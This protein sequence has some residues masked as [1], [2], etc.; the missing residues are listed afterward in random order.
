MNDLNDSMARPSPRPWYALQVHAKRESLVATQLEGQ[1]F[2]CFLPLY[3][4]VRRWSDRLKE[5]E[6]PLF[7]GY[8]FSRFDLQYR[9]PL[10]K[11]PGVQRIVGVGRTPMPV[12]ESEL[13]AIRQA[14]ASGLPNQ[15]WPFLRVGH[16]VR[17]NYGSMNNLE[18]VLVHF[19]GGHRVV[20]SVSLLQR[21][22]ALEI[23]LAWV[24]PVAQTEA[25]HGTK[26][27]VRYRPGALDFAW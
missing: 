25:G 2:E 21:S 26:E 20:L 1:G 8:L 4:S 14:L 11:T 27:V 9:L 24:K 22:V 16:R 6:Q 13:E 18:G 23:D 12:E 15:P 19:K 10:L 3:K 7:P 5:V 17:V